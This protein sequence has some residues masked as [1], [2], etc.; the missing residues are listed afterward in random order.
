MISVI[1][2]IVSCAAFLLGFL[3]GALVRVDSHVAQIQRESE[4]EGYRD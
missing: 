2:F 1:C 3:F 4:E